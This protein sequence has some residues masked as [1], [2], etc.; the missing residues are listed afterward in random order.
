MKLSV[1]LK[2]ALREMGANKMRSALM[3]A[4]IVVGIT[5]LTIIFAIGA[6]AQAR[7]GTA[8]ERVGIGNVIIVTS[9]SGGGMMIGTRGGPGEG[10]RIM[11]GTSQ[12]GVSPPGMPESPLTA[13]DVSA[14]RQLN[15]VEIVSPVSSQRNVEIRFG[16]QIYTTDLYGVEPGWER[17]T[18]REIAR[19]RFFTESEMEMA[20]R[21][22]VLGQTV[23]DELFAEGED[24]LGQAIRIGKTSFEVIGIFA[25]KSLEGMIVRGMTSDDVAV[26][27]ITTFNRSVSKDS[28]YSS[29]LVQPT[30][31][32]KISAIS[33]EMRKALRQERRIGPGDDEDFG[34]TIPR[35]VV[36]TRLGISGTMT[37]FLAVASIISLAV[38][39]VLIMNIMLVSVGERAREIGLRKALGARKKDILKQ[40]LLE[41]VAVSLVGGIIGIISGAAGSALVEFFTGMPVVVSWSVVLSGAFFAVLVG[42]LFGLQPARKAAALNPVEALRSE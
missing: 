2:T 33:E 31:V 27:P 13:A 8:L 36:Q 28:A 11:P 26:I 12:Q 4:G 10:T 22:V 5:V 19:G 29:I 39:G 42:I 15:G 6:G 3:A 14:L 7:V 20:E 1:A 24:P 16:A 41:A 25:A 18:N 35:E 9:R 17:L 37:I 32:N 23:V 40:F 21:V 34:I 30:N 38:G